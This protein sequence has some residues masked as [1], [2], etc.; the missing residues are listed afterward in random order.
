L[1]GADN[2]IKYATCYTNHKTQEMYFW[3]EG[4]AHSNLFKIR[5]REV[6][7]VIVSEPKIPTVICF[8]TFLIKSKLLVCR[9]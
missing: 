3:T 1:T 9:D 6:N 2:S 7:V 5:I 8:L 4:H